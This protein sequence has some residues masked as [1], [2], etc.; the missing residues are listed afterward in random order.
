MSMGYF[1]KKDSSVLLRG[2]ILSNT[3][4]HLFNNT[5][6]GKLEFLVIDFP[7][8]TGDIYLSLLKS[9][10]L[11]GVLLV[12]TSQD[13]VLDDLL[14]SII[15][16]K[17]FNIPILGLVNNMCSYKCLNCGYTDNMYEGV[18]IKKIVLNNNIP[19]LY[20]MPFDKSINKFLNNGESLIINYPNSY[21][22]SV[23][24][25]IARYIVNICV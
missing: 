23:Y 14:K 22:V 4:L 13:I 8:G 11:K 5:L 19:M 9:V 25:D 18:G 21:V 24:E 17:K 3:I 20:D 2:P 15:M 6:W 7:P 12:T 1:L 10:K 16:L